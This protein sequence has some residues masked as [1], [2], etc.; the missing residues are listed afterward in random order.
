MK[1]LKKL[2]KKNI[3]K[4]KILNKSS[5]K[6][7]VGKVKTIKK[8]K[9]IQKGGNPPP[10]I[11]EVPNKEGSKD[12]IRCLAWSH[13]GQKLATA[14]TDKILRIWNMTTKEIER[15]IDNEIWNSNYGKVNT[16]HT[17]IISSLSWS[18]SKMVLASAS[19]ENKV[20]LWN[21]EE[22]SNPNILEHDSEVLS[23]AW[24][25][26]DQFLACGCQNGNIYFWNVLEKTKKIYTYHK[27]AV[28]SLAF[29]QNQ[30][31]LTSADNHNIFLTKIKD[32]GL[33]EFISVK[34]PD[35]E[36][37]L[38]SWMMTTNVRGP[39]LISICGKNIIYWILKDSQL[40]EI[41]EKTELDY[42][43]KTIS[44]FS[45]VNQSILA[46]AGESNKIDIYDF[47]NNK[48]YQIELHTPIIHSIAWSPDGQLASTSSNM[49][50]QINLFF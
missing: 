43:I 46:V 38:L 6:K 21:F 14:S 39:L 20:L 25:Y 47:L 13:N 18:P 17:N 23:I 19:G 32:K 40:V 15:E 35:C 12:E 41:S 28:C 34:K 4:T 37:S 42:I 49:K 30:S 50:V 2:N 11:L 24:L 22:D 3:K 1:S 7:Y 8:S 45:Y 16:Y 26:Q 29:L 36:I 10:I 27:E 9:K 5:I 44:Y 48:I 31:I 33:K